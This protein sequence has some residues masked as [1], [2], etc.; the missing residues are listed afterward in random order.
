MTCWRR[1]RNWQ[2]EGGWQAL[3]E[4]LLAELYAAGRLDLHA[5]I[6]DSSHVHAL[7]GGAQTGPS[8]V[9]R[10]HLG[11]KH[12]LIT[13]RGGVPPAVLH[14]GGNRPDM[15]QLLPLVEAIPPIHGRPGR[16]NRRPRYRLADWA[17]DHRKDHRQLAAR[18]ITGCA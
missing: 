10:G 3:H 6:V 5:A 8:P 18:G 7:Q 9:N 14:P 11:A 4:T 2:A 17:Y 1:L 12:H 13:D 16:P 15:T